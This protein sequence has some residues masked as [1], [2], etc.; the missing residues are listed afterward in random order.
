VDTKTLYL[1][2]KLIARVGDPNR[3]NIVPWLHL[4]LKDAN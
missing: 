4:L 3:V 2:G 1:N